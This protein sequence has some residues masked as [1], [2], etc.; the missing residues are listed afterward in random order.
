MKTLGIRLTPDLIAEL[1]RL[2]GVFEFSSYG[3]M[4]EGFV[5]WR[6]ISDAKA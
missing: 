4:I 3:E 6:E 1:E 5:R 2:K